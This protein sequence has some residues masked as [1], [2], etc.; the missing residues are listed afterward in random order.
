MIQLHAVLHMANTN[1]C[2]AVAG[3]LMCFRAQLES[4]A[5]VLHPPVPLESTF[6]IAAQMPSLAHEVLNSRE[7]H[8]LNCTCSCTCTYGIVANDIASCA[9]ALVTLEAHVWLTISPQ[10]WHIT[11][12]CTCALLTSIGHDTMR[13]YRYIY[14]CSINGTFAVAYL[15]MHLGHD[16]TTR[17]APTTFMTPS[18]LDIHARRAKL[19][20]IA[21]T[22]TTTNLYLLLLLLPFTHLLQLLEVV[23]LLLLDLLLLLLLLLLIK[24]L[25]ILLLI[26]LRILLLILLL[27]ILLL[28]LLLIIILLLL[29]LLKCQRIIIIITIFDIIT[30]HGGAHVCRRC[31]VRHSHR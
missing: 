6:A 20:R 25:L 13:L 8:L 29:L 19:T 1:P 11:C 3:M 9:A 2:C 18:M 4:C 24:L 5:F 21:A 26:M 30:L 27:I 10:A 7:L 17:F 15:T 28:L 22:T 14:I 16:L 12:T 23:A 31:L